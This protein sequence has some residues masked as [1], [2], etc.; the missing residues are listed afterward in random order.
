MDKNK[1]EKTNEEKIKEIKKEIPS[2]VGICF[3]CIE[4]SSLRRL[5][6]LE[7]VKSVSDC[8]NKMDLCA[9]EQRARGYERFYFVVYAYHK[10]RDI[11]FY[12]QE[13]CI[14]AELGKDCKEEMQ[15]QISDKICKSYE[16]N[17][18][19]RWNNG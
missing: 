12:S 8:I 2:D 17:H 1:K 14:F 16:M 9:K 19:N 7:E 3:Q 6:C 10:K 11:S 5:Q 13:V 15:N 18:V 4:N